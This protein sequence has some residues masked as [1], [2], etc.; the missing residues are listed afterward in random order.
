MNSAQLIWLIGF[1]SYLPLHLG[2]PLLLALIREGRLPVGYRRYLWHGVLISLLVFV[3]AYTLSQWGL[4]W[5]LL[6]IALSAPL[7]WIQLR[8]MNKG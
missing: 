2:L 5:G 4:W 7:P 8:K 6:C 1:I 3:V